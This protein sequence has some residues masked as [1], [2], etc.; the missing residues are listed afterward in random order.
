MNGPISLCI[1]CGGPILPIVRDCR[2]ASEVFAVLLKLRGQLPVCVK[3]AGT[4][5][6]TFV[7]QKFRT[8][9]FVPF[10]FYVLLQIVTKMSFF[11]AFRDK[12]VTIEDFYRE[13]VVFKLNKENTLWHPVFHLKTIVCAVSHCQCAG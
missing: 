10:V 7:Q 8:K 2:Q 12:N 9:N 3:Q 6:R 13:N 5:C 4:I 11:L 1:L